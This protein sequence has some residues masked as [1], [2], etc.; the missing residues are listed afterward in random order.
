MWLEEA[1][2]PHLSGWYVL[3]R[4]Q[5]TSGMIETPDTL[6]TLCKENN[7]PGPYIQAMASQL[8]K[9]K[10]LKVQQSKV[11]LKVPGTGF[12]CFDGRP[13][14]AVGLFS[15]GSLNLVGSDIG[16]SF[17]YGPNSD[18]WSF[19]FGE[20]KNSDFDFERSLEVK[21][22]EGSSDDG[23]DDR[24]SLSDDALKSPN[25]LDLLS[26]NAADRKL[27]ENSLSDQDRSLLGAVSW[28]DGE[29]RQ[30]AESF[31]TRRNDPE[32]SKLSYVELVA[33]GLMGKGIVGTAVLDLGTGGVFN[34]RPVGRAISGE[35]EQAS[36]IRQPS[37]GHVATV[38]FE[39]GGRYQVA[40]LVELDRFDG[41]AAPG[42]LPK[43]QVSAETL[44]WLV[45]QARELKALKIERRDY[46]PEVLKAWDEQL[47]EIE[48]NVHAVA[49]FRVALSEV[50]QCLDGLGGE[51]TRESVEG[52][53]VDYVAR[54]RYLAG[55][56]LGNR[57]AFPE[58]VDET[59]PASSPDM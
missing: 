56:A 27:P 19:R 58:P 40:N 24:W 43:Q 41:N 42:K 32:G 10:P 45:T 25:W 28:P 47:A 49:D 5:T 55:V 3:H 54:A 37:S 33:S 29:W 51:I 11:E 4:A 21:L 13:K 17:T 30:E 35:V 22:I 46:S 36:E 14:L 8:H 16:D 6:V 1:G 12:L 44:Q 59:C 34:I 52:E 48:R 20:T 26:S 15:D 23:A 31:L 57:D 18:E 39:G 9:E 50:Q 53:N 2:E 38:R 7:E